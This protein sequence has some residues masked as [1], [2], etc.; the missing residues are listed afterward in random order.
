MNLSIGGHPILPQNPGIL[1]LPSSY[2]IIWRNGGCQ[3]L[4][5]G[6]DNPKPHS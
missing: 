1:T 3:V 6:M 4:L 5:R 2:V